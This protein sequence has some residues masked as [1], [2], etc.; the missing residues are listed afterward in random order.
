V[1]V[2]RSWSRLANAV[3]AQLKSLD[4][5]G[6]LELLTL[7]DILDDENGFLRGIVGGIMGR[8][9]GAERPSEA[10]ERWLAE[11]AIVYVVDHS[12]ATSVGRGVIG[13]SV[14]CDRKDEYV[15][16]M[17]K[18]DPPIQG[19]LVELIND[20]NADKAKGET[21]QLR[22]LNKR[23]EREVTNL[24]ERL[25][26]SAA[27]SPR[28]RSSSA[29]GSAGAGAGA[30]GAGGVAGAAGAGAPL[31]PGSQTPGGSSSNSSSSSSS[32]SLSED[33]AGKLR[34]AERRAKTA[35]ARLE[36]LEHEAADAA[37]AAV[38]Q[39]RAAE[40]R[41]ARAEEELRVQAD[42][43]DVARGKAAQLVKS[44][45]KVTKLMQKLEETAAL[46]SQLKELQDESATSFD[47]KLEMEAEVKQAAALRAQ[48]DEARRRASEAEAAAAQLRAELGARDAELA[49]AA[50]KLR[51]AAEHEKFLREQIEASKEAIAQLE[52]EADLATPGSPKPS[53]P[54]GAAAAASAASLA[55][56][57]QAREANSVKLKR[58]EFEERI[59]VLE[60]EREGLLAQLA[61][62]RAEGAAKAAAAAEAAKAAAAAAPA[63][64]PLQQQLAD[65]DAE[66]ANLQAA[67]D[68]LR[69]YLKQVLAETQQKYK[70]A[71][72]SL[73]TQVDEKNEMISNFKSIRDEDEATHRREQRL[74][75]SSFYE[76]GLEMQRRTALKSQQPPGSWLV[77]SR[78]NV[79]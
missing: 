77:K 52:A 4:S 56:E 36:A 54:G 10:L 29:A 75:M 31:T 14:E 67:H 38:A 7:N 46:R 20:F 19:K 55:A 12:D 22:A 17:M 35:E 45:A 25:R 70:L 64:G 50:G 72:K 42:E 57:Q 58:R 66:C 18:L 47:R 48:L 28:A 49:Q 61:A 6:D 11:R 16:S 43:L 13:A 27:G 5:G 41:A 26:A 33:A 78:K 34:E 24:R 69:A 15:M 63:G 71:I 44:E 51:A 40:E 68:K 2:G 3:T 74:V 1:R 59:S 73:Q 37:A 9:V 30:G 8:K 65:K 62:A 79:P 39:V 21:D 53:S 32:S 60:R 23:L 76:L